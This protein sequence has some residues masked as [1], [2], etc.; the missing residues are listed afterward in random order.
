[1]RV[2][3]SVGSVMHLRIWLTFKIISPTQHL[4]IL[5]SD[6][7]ASYIFVS[8]EGKKPKQRKPSYLFVG[9]RGGDV[10]LLKNKF[11]TKENIRK[12]IGL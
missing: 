1:M 10:S 3:L 11:V 2:L 6:F 8:T 12:K 7:M 5:K 9:N 4:L